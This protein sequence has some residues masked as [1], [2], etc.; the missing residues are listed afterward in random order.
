MRAGWERGIPSRMPAPGLALG[1][2]GFFGLL[3]L[4]PELLDVAGGGGGLGAEDVRVAADQLLVDGVEGVVDG[5]EVL[6]GGH[7]G[8]EDGLEEEVAEF[9]GE[10]GPVAAVDG[11]EDL[12]GLFEGVGFDGV[13][14]LLAVP[15][16]AGFGAELRH[17]S[18]QLREFFAG[19]RHV[20]G[21]LTV[22][23]SELEEGSRLR[24]SGIGVSGLGAGDGGFGV[25]CGG[26]VRRGGAVCGDLKKR[27]QLGLGFG[28][29]CGHV[30]VVAE[31][32]GNS[33]ARVRGGDGEDAGD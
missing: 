14:G 31:A 4:V 23:R 3:D 24:V 22:A 11:V 27:S 5:E 21:S 6:V 26:C 7:L 8:V 15:G 18:D 12:V 19:G 33:Q 9:F 29:N 10:V 30:C 25:V 2:G 16:A 28:G 32:G 1:G 17:N 13:E 20:G